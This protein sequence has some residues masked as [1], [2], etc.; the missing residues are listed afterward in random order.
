[1]T[2]V[3]NSDTLAFDSH[4]DK[5]VNPAIWGETKK[6]WIFLLLAAGPCAYTPNDFG[7]H[8]PVSSIPGCHGIVSSGMQ[9]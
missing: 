9:P 4:C 6:N 5:N 2:R 3:G 7:I 1:M 8:G